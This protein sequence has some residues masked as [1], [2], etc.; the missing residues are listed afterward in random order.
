MKK[1][2]FFIALIMTLLLTACGEDEG[3]EGSAVSTPAQGWHFQGRDCLACHNVDL[4][5]ERH[6]VFGGS[7]Y[8]TEDNNNDV[9][10]SCGGE[11]NVN[12]WDAS[13]SNLL[14][15]SK[16][17]V[18]A[19]SKGNLGKGNIFILQRMFQPNSLNGNLFIEITDANNSVLASYIHQFSSGDYDINNPTDAS[20]RISCNACHG[21]NGQSHIYV[22]SNKVSLCQ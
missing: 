1:I 4:Q 18:D 14:Y 2:L 19:N 17:F 7:V 15:A 16:N 22:D 6:L 8:K 13:R 9:Q 12:I 21:Q 20:N 11:L 10:N 5:D 3:G